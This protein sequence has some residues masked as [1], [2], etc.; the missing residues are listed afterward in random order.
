MAVLPQNNEQTR[1]ERC[2][3]FNQYVADSQGHTLV[4]WD[5]VGGLDWWFGEFNSKWEITS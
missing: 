1:N 5:L 2:P 4:S 3:S